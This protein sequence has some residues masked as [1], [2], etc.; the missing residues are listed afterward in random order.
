MAIGFD[1]K[2]PLRLTMDST[3]CDQSLVNMISLPVFLCHTASPRRHIFLKSPV[4]W[5]SRMCPSSWMCSHLFRP[6]PFEYT[7]F[8][9]RS[10][11]SE[12][13]QLHNYSLNCGKEQNGAV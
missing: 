1:Q 2:A 8:F 3:I 6:A 10:L 13:L 11:S 4:C 5:N 7:A 9:A 12:R